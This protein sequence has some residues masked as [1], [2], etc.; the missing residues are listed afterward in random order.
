MSGKYWDATWNPV[1]GCT[2]V[3]PGCDNCWARVMA[4]RLR[5]MGST[6]MKTKHVGWVIEGCG[7]IWTTLT[8]TFGGTR[9]I[10]ICDFM[11]WHN[12]NRQGRGQ[13][14]DSWRALRRRGEYRCVK[15]YVEVEG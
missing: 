15:V 14:P 9:N 2:A 3:S 1:T 8:F 4:K 11:S 12:R 6:G 10:A 7:D 5:A 13:K